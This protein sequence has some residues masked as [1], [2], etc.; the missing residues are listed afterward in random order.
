[1]YQLLAKGKGVT[2]KRGLEEGGGK[3]ATWGTRNR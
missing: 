3:P 1:L 2:A